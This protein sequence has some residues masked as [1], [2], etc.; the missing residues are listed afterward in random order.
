MKLWTSF[1]LLFSAFVVRAQQPGAAVDILHYHFSI[2]LSDSSDRIAGEASIRFKV[3]RA[4]KS[5]SLQL[6]REA[7]EGKGMTVSSVRDE[8]L[9]SYTHDRTTLRINFGSSLEPG[10]E[11]TIT[12]TY[13]G[14][15]ADGLII[16][17]NKYGHRGFFADH[18]PDRA[19]HWLPCV[20]HP[21]DKA[22][23]SFSITA[24]DHYQVVANGRQTEESSLGKGLKLTRY[25]ETTPL[26]TKVMVIGVADFAVQEAGRVDCIPVQSWIYPEDRLKGFTDYAEALQVLPYYIKNIG[27]YGYPKLANV[28]SKTRFGGLENASAIFYYENSVTGTG[29]AVALIA[30]EIA[31]Q[32]FGNMATEKEWAHVWLSEGFATYMTNLYMEHRYGRDTLV[33]MLQQQRKE[34]IDYT[35]RKSTPVVDSS[36]TDYMDLLN[37]NSYQKAGWILH[38][39]HMQLG[40]S[41]FWRSI[42]NY[43]AEYAG[44]NASTEDLQAVFESTSGKKLDLFF[45]QWLY[46]AGHPDLDIR[47][48]YDA[49]RKLLQVQIEQ[50]QAVAFEFPLE[51]RITGGSEDGVITKSV[52]VKGKLTS[53]AIPMI[54]KP[55]RWQVDPEVKLL[56]QYQLTEKPF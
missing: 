4:T 12:V 13:T 33:A 15:P 54:E 19:R 38:M 23:V 46:R 52:Q 22:S 36:I 44:K 45:T 55:Q 27:P 26:P 20:D 35:K 41:I 17:K 6:I 24:P 47:W 29:K 5:V 1:F 34:V 56:F 49:T 14:I 39:L 28:Q 31:H 9:L 48:N 3:L 2:T 8:G 10:T 25:D 7:G 50:R 16:G 43:Y 51:V 40:D 21:A 42:R 11:K 53:F 18:W 37:P 32:W 30:H